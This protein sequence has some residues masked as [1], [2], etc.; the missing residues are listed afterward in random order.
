MGEETAT[1]FPTPS[2]GVFHLPFGLPPSDGASLLPDGTTRIAL[3]LDI[4][5][6][7]LS[8]A[9]PREVL[10]LDG[11][12]RVVTLRV[13]R[14]LTHGEVGAE[15]PWFW[16]GGGN[17]DSFIIEWHDTFSLPQGGRESTPRNR[18]RYDYRRDG[19][20]RIL[21]TD[22]SPGIGDIRLTAGYP[23]AEG[24]GGHLSLRGSLSLPTGD[25]KRLRGIGAPSLALSLAGDRTRGP[26]GIWGSLGGSI[27]GEGDILPDMRQTLAGFALLGCGWSP[28]TPL[29]LKLEILGSTPL[30]RESAMTAIAGAPL[31][32]VMGGT[33]SLSDTMV[34][35][36]GVSEDI[37]VESSADVALHAGVRYTF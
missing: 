37:H 29:T 3:S 27:A 13:R 22:P 2:Q 14:G 33:L 8:H 24:E 7:S 16:T 4:A 12:S 23:L 5:S 26:F 18:F 36:I 31:V 25:P 21:L 15:I 35:D 30:F 17:F 34:L 1:P 9:T 28:V 10:I 19:T 6:T 32:L 11:E 20:Q